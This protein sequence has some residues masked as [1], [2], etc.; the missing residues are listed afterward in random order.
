[1]KIAL[2]VHDLHTHG[3]HSLYTKVLADEL[4]K[5]HAVSVFANHCERPAESA[6]DARPVRA[7]RGSALATVK[8]FPLG[9]RAHAAELAAYDIRHSQGYCGGEPNVVTA[10][11]CVAAYL[12]SL[13]EV[14]LRHRLSLQRMAAAESRF[15]HSFKGRLIAVSR[16]VAAELQQHYGVTG[17]VDVIP[18]GVDTSR[19]NSQNRERFRID[20]RRELGLG[21]S[22][23]LALYAGDLTKAH[24]HLKELSLACPEVQFV[25][26]THSRAYHWRAPNVRILPP[27]SDLERY[28]AAADAFVFPTTYDAFGMVALEAMASGLPVFSSDQAGAAELIHSGEDG[29]VIPLSDWVQETAEHLRDRTPLLEIG[30]NAEQT[31]RAHDWSSVVTAVEQIYRQVM[32]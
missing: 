18:H 22:E 9:L 5:H 23:T 7:W 24:V 14:S 11:I 12:K 4:S 17:Q 28:Y 6:W 3:G 32:N 27:V 29:F 15:Y 30:N 31:A 16:K 2:I 26:V 25:V 20:L 8:T 10:H 13:R 19:F 1:L 21:N